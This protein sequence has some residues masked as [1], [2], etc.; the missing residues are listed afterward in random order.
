M[1]IDP[2]HIPKQK[3]SHPAHHCMSRCATPDSSSLLTQYKIPHALLPH[4][5]TCLPHQLLQLAKRLDK[6]GID[7]ASLPAL[8]LANHDDGSRALRRARLAELRAALDVDVRHAV[9]LAQHGDMGD[10]VH[11]RDISGDDDDGGGVGRVRGARFAQGF[12][13]FFYAAA[14]GFGFGGWGVA[15]ACHATNFGRRRGEQSGGG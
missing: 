5:L 14:E 6:L 3:I 12:D 2:S 10:D 7:L 9:V 8:I 1:H 15:L 11:G 4:S 13:D